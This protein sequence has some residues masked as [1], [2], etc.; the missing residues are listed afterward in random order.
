MNKWS[1]ED[2]RFM[3]RALAIAR[4]AEGRVEPNPMVGCVLVKRGRIVGEGYHR[5]FGGP[6]AEVN[7]IASAGRAAKGATA[8]VTLEPCC[9]HGK[10]PPCTEALIRSGVGSVIAAMKDPN[11]LVAGKGLRRLRAAG[12]TTRV[13]LLEREAEVLTAPFITRQKQRRPYFILKWAQSLDGKIA[14][15]TGDSQ[16]ITSLASRREAHRLRARVDAVIVGVETVLADDPELTARHAPR[17]R[18]AARVVLDSRLRTPLTARVVRTANVTPTLIVT[19]LMGIR[20]KSRTAALEAAGCEVIAM[21]STQSEISLPALARELYRRSMTNVMVEG[22]GR[23]LGSF[24]DSGL[25]DEAMIFVAPRLIGGA[26]AP[27]PLGGLGPRNMTDLA[28]LEVLS[29]RRLGVDLCYNVRFR[30]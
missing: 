4:R 11:P 26:E 1:Q 9:H 15:R 16:W 29:V 20:R 25:G 28:A 22:G 5:V 14:T 7:A 8:Y 2:E 21:K 13:G 27:G 30:R 3:R 10:T 23:I 19:S 12:I 24:F 6:H 17:R 18:T